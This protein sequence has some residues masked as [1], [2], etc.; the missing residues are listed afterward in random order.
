MTSRQSTERFFSAICWGP[1]FPSS[2]VLNPTLLYK[3]LCQQC[4]PEC[5]ATGCCQGSVIVAM[6]EFV[7]VKT[8]LQ[9]HLAVSTWWEA[10][11]PGCMATVP[12]SMA[13]GLHAPSLWESSWSVNDKRGLPKACSPLHGKHQ[14]VSWPVVH[15]ARPN[16]GHEP[17]MVSIAHC[18]RGCYC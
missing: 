16:M 15:Y 2:L 8:A 10:T 11:C 6:L 9:C 5:P 1:D 17:C 4:F 7:L 18:T 14:S 3:H 12:Y 13:T